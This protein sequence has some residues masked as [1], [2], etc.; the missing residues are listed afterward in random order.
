[1]HLLIHIP[2]LLADLAAATHFTVCDVPQEKD[3]IRREAATLFRERAETAD[4]EL[5]EQQV[6]CD[7]LASPSACS[8][9]RSQWRLP[10]FTC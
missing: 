7:M 4:Q 2:C 6:R 10:C 8:C 5:I 3:Y 9:S 1:M